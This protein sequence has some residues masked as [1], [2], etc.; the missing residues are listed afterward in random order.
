MLPNDCEASEFTQD[1]GVAALH[2]AAMLLDVDPSVAGH[3]VSLGA[4]PLFLSR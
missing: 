4:V 2:V 3:M 1:D